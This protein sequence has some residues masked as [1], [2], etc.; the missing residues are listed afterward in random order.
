MPPVHAKA[1]PVLLTTEAD[2]ETWLT[3]PPEAVP[4]LQRPAPNGDLRV[5]ATGQ[6]QDGT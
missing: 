3:G 2:R 1:M 4:A 6:K 5:I